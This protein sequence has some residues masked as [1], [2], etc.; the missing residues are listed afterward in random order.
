[1]NKKE[2]TVDTVFLE[3]LSCDGKILKFLR[4]YCQI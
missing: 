4:K 1:M 2:V 3:K